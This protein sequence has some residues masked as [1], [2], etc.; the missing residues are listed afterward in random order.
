MF[1]QDARIS[2]TA[3]GSLDRGPALTSMREALA[4]HLN[5]DLADVALDSTCINP[6]AANRDPL[7]LTGSQCARRAGELEAGPSKVVFEVMVR[8]LCAYV[9]AYG[10]MRCVVLRKR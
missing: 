7:A 5:I 2:D 1:L 8:L 6:A 3:A 9:I 10:G 4:A